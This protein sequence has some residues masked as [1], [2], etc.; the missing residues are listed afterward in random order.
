MSVPRI[1]IRDL[2]NFSNKDELH[3][4]YSRFGAIRNIWVASNPPG[5]AYV[6]YHSPKDAIRA[7]SATNGTYLFGGNVRVEFSP[8]EDKKDYNM[9]IGR[10]PNRSL[11]PQPSYHHHDDGNRGNRYSP[12]HQRVRSRS[13]QQQQQQQRS[14]HGRSQPS[15]AP[16]TR[17]HRG[18]S[19][20]DNSSRSNY[21]H[22]SESRRGYHQRGASPPP[23]HRNYSS[24]TPEK[25]Y[26]GNDHHVYHGHG[27]YNERPS[28]RGGRSEQRSSAKDYVVDRY[29]NKVQHRENPPGRG[30]STHHQMN[31]HRDYTRNSRSTSQQYGSDG[32]EHHAHTRGPPRSRLQTQSNHNYRREE[33]YRAVPSSRGGNHH[34]RDRG[35][36][37]GHYRQTRP[38][39]Q[40]RN[41]R[42]QGN[43]VRE[44]N[45]D[46]NRRP[47]Q[48]S[49][50]RNSN[51]RHSRGN[52]SHR[53]QEDRSQRRDRP[54]FNSLSS[55]CGVGGE[56]SSLQEEY[57]LYEKD[58]A[59]VYSPSPRPQD[60][61][62]PSEMSGVEGDDSHR[63]GN[64]EEEFHRSSTHTT[65]PEYV[66]GELHSNYK[67]FPNDNV[68]NYEYLHKVETEDVVQENED[69][70]RV[71]IS[72][73]PQFIA[74]DE[75]PEEEDFLDASIDDGEKSPPFYP[76]REVTYSPTYSEREVVRGER[77]VVRLSTERE[78]HLSRSPSA[79][80]R[81][82]ISVEQ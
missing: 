36:P 19:Y 73:D 29:M 56:F 10:S 31:Y 63:K 20:S 45:E 4:V 27:E 72:N 18:N 62:H 43:R 55:P 34:P 14:Y 51:T 60:E 57:A 6:F 24:A 2:G 52:N 64:E 21:H 15:H 76:E 82:V 80:Q 11:H 13:P 42:R 5:F 7:V 65:P 37:D 50:N 66:S 8:T 9:R 68:E 30:S 32:R 22:S 79:I 16:P 70:E 81:L 1:I 59:P 3:K 46:H 69:Q 49:S 58:D 48:L 28:S 67:D 12:H 54:S 53:S 23:T 75:H 44:R 78:V 40:H 61:Y 38:Q 17:D 26:R 71:Y 77:E 25:Y 39:E 74:S 47:L 33:Q 35:P 41:D